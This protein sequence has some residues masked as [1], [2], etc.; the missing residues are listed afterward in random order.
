[1]AVLHLPVV[2]TEYQLALA[3]S[4]EYVTVG[5]VLGGPKF[6]PTTV[7]VSPTRPSVFSKPGLV[8]TAVTAGGV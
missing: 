8:L 2:N 1:M 4:L 5:T 6:D 3:K 7:I